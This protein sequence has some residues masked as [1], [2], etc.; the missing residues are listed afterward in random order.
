M[1]APLSARKSGLSG[2]QEQKIALAK[3]L[4]RK[5]KILL[6]DEAVSNLDANSKQRVLQHLRELSSTV[7][8]VSHD[9]VE[10]ATADRVVVV[11]KGRIAEEQ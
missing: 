7:I 11:E 10:I 5:P 8:F 9:P 4:I 2:G 3:A 6:L 1:T